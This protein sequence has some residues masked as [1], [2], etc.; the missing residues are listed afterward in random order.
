MP[1][2][3][4][5]GSNSY[6]DTHHQTHS[7]FFQPHWHAQL[8][9]KRFFLLSLSL[10]RQSSNLWCLSLQPKRLHYIYSRFR[11]EMHDRSKVE[12]LSSINVEPRSACARARDINKQTG[13]F[14]RLSSVRRDV[15]TDDFRP[16]GKAR[17]DR[18]CVGMSCMQGPNRHKRSNGLHRSGV[19]FAIQSF[20]RSGLRHS[21]RPMSSSRIINPGKA[22]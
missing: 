9:W 17:P 12:L 7:L 21:E 4:I 19:A 13:Y 14:Y 22:E 6:T 2:M 10:I 20:T 5:R 16:T 18:C 1:K 11:G 3:L 15:E 8:W